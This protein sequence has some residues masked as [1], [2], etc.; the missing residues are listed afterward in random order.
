ML[1]GVAVCRAGGFGQRQPR[2]RSQGPHEPLAAGAAINSRQSG[3]PQSAESKAKRMPKQ[4]RASKHQHDEPQYDTAVS[5]SRVAQAEAAS[6]ETGQ[7]PKITP[8]G[9]GGKWVHV[10]T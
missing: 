4:K 9:G 3:S 6:I 1:D 5:G 10:P 2:A 7:A 8:S